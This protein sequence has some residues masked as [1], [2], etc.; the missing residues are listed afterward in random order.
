MNDVTSKIKH[1]ATVEMFYISA[2][3]RAVVDRFKELEANLVKLYEM[4]LELEVEV[5]HWCKHGILG[6]ILFFP[7]EFLMP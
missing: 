2:G 4:I 5:F 1:W 7:D 6:T 3:D